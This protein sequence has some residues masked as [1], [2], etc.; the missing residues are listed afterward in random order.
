MEFDI[1]NTTT[2]TLYY[3]VSF[4]AVSMQN[5]TYEEIFNVFSLIPLY[6]LYCLYCLSF[7]SSLSSL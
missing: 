2:I 1:Q 6:T 5:T 7:L 4:H 3:A